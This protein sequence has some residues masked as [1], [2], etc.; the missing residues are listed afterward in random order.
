MKPPIK[1]LRHD[2]AEAAEQLYRAL[3]SMPCVC[4]FKWVSPVR[5][6]RTKECRKCRALAGWDA[7]R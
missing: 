3:N 1:D 7:L 2:Y 6:E 4:E 5:Q